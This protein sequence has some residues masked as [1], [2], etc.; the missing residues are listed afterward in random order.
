MSCPDLQH[1]GCVL[2]KGMLDDSAYVLRDGCYHLRSSE[3]THRGSSFSSNETGERTE[4]MVDDSLFQVQQEDSDYFNETA[5]PQS[6]I[7][8]FIARLVG[9][10]VL[11]TAVI[12]VILFL[13]FARAI[14]AFMISKVGI[15][16]VTAVVAVL[17]YMGMKYGG[18]S[19]ARLWN[20]ISRAVS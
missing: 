20:T 10:M 9:V 8:V 16:G 13:M 12:L 2:S 7:V 1:E 14:M 3:L 19:R 17:V 4:E 6:E 5:A 15:S 11:I 18:I